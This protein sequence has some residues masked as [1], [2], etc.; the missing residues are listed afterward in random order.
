MIKNA[1]THTHAAQDWPTAGQINGQSKKQRK[2]EGK[3][4]RERGRHATHIVAMNRTP[5]LGFVIYPVQHVE[6]DRQQERERERI[7]N[8]ASSGGDMR[9]GKVSKG[10]WSLNSKHN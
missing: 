2:R 4:V 3:G 5:S 6:H 8:W 7:R 10:I 9:D 1:H